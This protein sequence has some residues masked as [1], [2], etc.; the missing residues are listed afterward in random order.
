MQDQTDATDTATAATV[1]LEQ[2]MTKYSDAL[3]FKTASE[4][5]SAD[6]SYT[7][8][9][10]LGLVDQN[11]VN[12]LNTQLEYKRQLDA[13]IITQEEYIEK[14]VEL[15]EKTN[16]A[17]EASKNAAKETENL[18]YATLDASLAMSNYTKELLFKIASEGLSAESALDLAEK[19][20]LV[21]QTT[22][23]A[24][25]SQ[26]GWRQML[27]SNVISQ[28]EYNIRIADMADKLDTLKAQLEAGTITQEEYNLAL[29]QMALDMA[30][31]QDKTVRITLEGAGEAKTDLDDINAKIQALKDRSI[32]VTTNHLEY[33]R[34]YGNIPQAQAIGG[35]VVGGSPYTW[36]EYGY[37][38][39]LFVPSQNG[40]VLS[41]A[42]AS[43]IIAKA[44]RGGQEKQGGD[45][46]I[47]VYGAADPDQVA[48]QIKM[49]LQAA[50][51]II[52][53]N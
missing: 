42:E 46:N 3:L 41:R 49:N 8:A 26:Q 52:G 4:G 2:A 34:I 1:S 20:G 22:V 16:A 38:G 14:T 44:L 47:T 19:M 27:D 33:Y 23:T 32:T 6:A 7:L 24:W 35:P 43:D 21:D 39:E 30:A 11:T 53:V 15:A 36:Q 5:L 12:A 10:Q 25:R 17:A 37:G 29:E 31:L 51:A 18:R 9:E 40:Y 50:R 13:G 45:I 48:N 28:D